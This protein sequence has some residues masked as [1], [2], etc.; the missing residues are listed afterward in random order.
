MWSTT[1]GGAA[2]GRSRRLRSSPGRWR[3][4]PCGCWPP[5]SHQQSAVD[6][7][8][9]AGDVVAVGRDEIDDGAADFLHRPESLQG[10]LAQEPV[11][12][13]VRNAPNHVRLD[14]P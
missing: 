13:L 11:A 7:Q 4:T 2:P 6:R 9:G 14:E 10:N 1:S 8:L 12:D 5:W 3:P